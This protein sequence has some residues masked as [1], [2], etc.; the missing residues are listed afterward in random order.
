LPVDRFS[1]VLSVVRDGQSCSGFSFAPWLAGMAD[2]NQTVT[3]DQM[4]G[5]IGS[6]IFLWSGIERE[7]TSAIGRLQCAENTKAVHGISKSI[8]L[9]SACVTSKGSDEDLRIE[10]CQRLVRL[11]R[12]ALIVRNL[13]CHGLV[14][15]RVGYPAEERGAYLTVELGDEKRFLHWDELQEMFSWM[16][17]AR[18]LVNDLT[19]ATLQGDEASATR[20]LQGWTAF[21]A[22]S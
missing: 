19:C 4:K 10:L 16:S 3:F 6:L 9:W 8:D 7:I 5:A 1:D 11:L 2:S 12:E 21:P 14:G 22:Q 17:K 15:I 13:F 18:F 20:T